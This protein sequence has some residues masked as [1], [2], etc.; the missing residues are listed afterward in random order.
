MHLS[1]ICQPVNIFKHLSETIG[2]IELKCHI[3]LRVREEKF[4]NVLIMH[5]IFLP[6]SHKN[7]VALVREIV[8]MLQKHIIWIL[9]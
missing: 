7:Y 4:G 2:P 6:P 9:G 3:E 8:K 1:I 5:I